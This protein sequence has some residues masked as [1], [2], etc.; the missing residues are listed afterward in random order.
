[1]TESCIKVFGTMLVAVKSKAEARVDEVL[2]DIRVHI[3]RVN[4]G[5][6][7]IVMP[8]RHA[9]RLAQA[10]DLAEY[11][12]RFRYAVRMNRPLPIQQIVVV[13]ATES[14]DADIII[15]HVKNIELPRRLR[16]IC[17]CPVIKLLVEARESGKAVIVKMHV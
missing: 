13:A 4:G 5:T 16:R 15:G 11:T 9:K 17:S 12:S 6:F 2:D 7:G 8:D 10:I 3:I 1:M 14:D